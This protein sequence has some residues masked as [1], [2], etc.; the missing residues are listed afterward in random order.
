MNDPGSAAAALNVVF[1][2]A[3]IVLR[4][5]SALDFRID[6]IGIFR[7]CPIDRQQFS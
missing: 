3:S 4:I 7:V 1:L 5:P 6:L 2:L